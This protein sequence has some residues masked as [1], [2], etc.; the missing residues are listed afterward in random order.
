MNRRLP[1]F[2]WSLQKA[3]DTEPDSFA[4]ARINIIYTILLFSLLKGVVIISVTSINGQWLQMARA[5][6]V[7]VIYAVLTKILLYVPSRMK[8]L[9]HIMILIGIAVVWSNIFIYAH[10]INLLTI[11]FVFMVIMSSFYILG[12]TLGIWYS[13]ISILPVML[14]LV[15]K[16]NATAYFTGLVGQEIAS[17][18]FEIMVVLNFTS[19][20]ISNYLFYEA[21]RINIREKETLNRQLLIAVDE[22]NK[23]A[24]TKSN[25]LSTISHELRT[26]LNSVVGISELLLADK[27]EERQRENLRILQFS[28][29]D[30]LSLINNVLDFNKL[31]SEKLVLETVPMH[32]AGFMRNI[33]SGL[34]IKATNKQ[35]DFILDI[36][37]RIENLYVVSDPTRLSQVIYNLVSNAIKFTE[38]GSVTVKLD[39]TD[40]TDQQA[41]ILFSVTDTGIGIHPD[42]HHTIFELFT[43]AESHITRKYGG[44]GLGLAIVKQILVLFSSEIQLDSS[45]GNGTTFSFTIPFTTTQPPATEVIIADP[46]KK[47]D[48]SHLKILVAEDNNFNRLIIEKQ[49]KMLGVT[50]LIV[51]NGQLAYDTYLNGHFDA[52]LIDLHMPV[53][54]GYETTKKIRSLTNPEKSGIYIIAF[55]ASVNEQEQ[56][57]NAGF[58]DYLYK[59]VNMGDLSDKLDLIAHKVRVG[60]V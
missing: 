31:D 55:T 58:D 15:F 7:L 40:K 29:L 28:A 20:I 51:E 26:P 37:D 3:L 43:Q 2:N 14:V 25:F 34:K 23:L 13:V 56:I 41:R 44:T 9:A 4:K 17:P 19:I 49:M 57:F 48:L 39:C 18:G 5:S 8:L 52:I 32:L 21:F 11:Q 60:V 16:D 45:P 1:F 12:S 50:P 33:C 36:D 38:T 10:K 59:P 47:V 22:A 6:I 35:L 53:S 30:L 27:P 42:R 24:A 46:A 54:D